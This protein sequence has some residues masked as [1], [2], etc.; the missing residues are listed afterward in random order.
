M[1]ILGKS[2]ICFNF[3]QIDQ[4]PDTSGVYVLL[5]S[6][7]NQSKVI[8]IGMSSNLRTRI[9]THDREDCW[10]AHCSG[11]LYVCIREMINSKEEQ[12]R[13]LEEELRE[14]Y[15]PPCGER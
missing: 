2:F 3:E 9:Q 7:Q 1:N 8:D 13:E 10:N 11:T 14:T 12:I 4:I 6:R 15:E 5:C